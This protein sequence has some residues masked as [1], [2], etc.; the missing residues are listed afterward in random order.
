MKN[1]VAKD[2]K[3]KIQNNEDVILIDTL[4]KESFCAKHIPGSINMPTDEIK[5]YAEYVLPDKNQ[6]LIVYCANT[7]CLKSV[8]AKEKLIELGY[9]NV[10]HYPEG[11]SGWLKDG[12]KLVGTGEHLKADC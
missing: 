10:L 7:T 3:Q 8:H 9:K 4:S 6:N 5:K 11:L 2:I 1:L 12:F